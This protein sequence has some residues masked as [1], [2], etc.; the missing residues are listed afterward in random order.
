MYWWLFSGGFTEGFCRTVTRL[1]VHDAGLELRTSV[2]FDIPVSSCTGWGVFPEYPGGIWCFFHRAV[3]SLLSLFCSLS[4]SITG[5]LVLTS[6]LI[7]CS[8]E[9]RIYSVFA[10]GSLSAPQFHPQ[11]GWKLRQV[12]EAISWWSLLGALRCRWSDSSVK[13]AW[14]HFFSKLPVLCRLGF[15]FRSAGRAW[16]GLLLSGCGGLFYINNGSG[17]EHS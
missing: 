17:D 1:Y 15:T 3:T 6:I 4:A 16:R 13:C 14:A 2:E 10:H 5:V 12:R 9:Q 8:A 11:W 7:V